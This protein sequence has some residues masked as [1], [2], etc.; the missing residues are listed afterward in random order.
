MATMTIKAE[1][2]WVNSDK[3][4]YFLAADEVEFVE[5]SFEIVHISGTTKR[6]QG[7]VLKVSEVE[8]LKYELSKAAADNWVKEQMKEGLKRAGKT[9]LRFAG[10]KM[11][12]WASQ[13]PSKPRSGSSSNEEASKKGFDAF[14]RAS[15]R[16]KQKLDGSTGLNS[17]PKELGKKL[18][19][20]LGLDK[21]S[22]EDRAGFQK[23]MNELK[24]LLN[25][26]KGDVEKG[27]K[28]KKNE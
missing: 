15:K 8:L 13:K 16:F 26:I 3:T 22:T 19:E 14:S 9:A 4:R 18:E 10:Q 12:K 24:G 6:H 25:S 7:K 5:G 27:I 28:K 17:D 2:L 20:M 1:T 11:K 23:K 21:L